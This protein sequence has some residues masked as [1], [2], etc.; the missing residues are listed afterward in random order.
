LRLQLRVLKLRLLVRTEVAEPILEL[1][2]IRIGE[3]SFKYRF[4]AI[5]HPREV[6]DVQQ[7]RLQDSLRVSAF[8]AKP[9]GHGLSFTQRIDQVVERATGTSTGL[10]VEALFPIGRL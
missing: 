3:R 6:A 9:D 1:L 5:H 4:G 7:V 8:V 10:P 2:A